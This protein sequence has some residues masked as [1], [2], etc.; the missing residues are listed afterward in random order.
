MS[1]MTKNYALNRLAELKPKVEE[2]LRVHSE[3]TL[4]E[5]AEG[6]RPLLLAGLQRAVE[7]GSVEKNDAARLRQI[8][9]SHGTPRTVVKASRSHV[10]AGLDDGERTEQDDMLVR[11]IRKTLARVDAA[12]A[13]AVAAPSVSLGTRKDDMNKEPVQPTLTVY[14][15]YEFGI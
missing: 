3:T 12:I 15:D 13:A 4:A 1:H 9:E 14:T 11:L 8:L 2:M 5:M 10:E 6:A 7:Q